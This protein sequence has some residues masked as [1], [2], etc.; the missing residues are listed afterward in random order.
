[1]TIR[2]IKSLPKFLKMTIH[3]K[4]QQSKEGDDSDVEFSRNAFE[5]II[6]NEH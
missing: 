6:D 5:I 2:Q 3:Q 4:N 1:M